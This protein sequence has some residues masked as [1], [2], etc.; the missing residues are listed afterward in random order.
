M[1]V[2]GSDQ[3]LAVTV[4]EVEFFGVGHGALAVMLLIALF[5][6]ATLCVT[7]WTLRGIQRAMARAES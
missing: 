7:L 3:C 2:T 5:C 6:Y 4:E 1:G